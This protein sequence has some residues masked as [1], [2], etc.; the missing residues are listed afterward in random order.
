MYNDCEVYNA[1]NYGPMQ[2]IEMNKI[3]LGT[4]SKSTMITGKVYS[5]DNIREHIKI[6]DII[7]VT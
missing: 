3:V 7:D 4:N 6:K 5:R 2:N 1:S